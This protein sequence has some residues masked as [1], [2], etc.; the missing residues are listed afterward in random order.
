MVDHV[1]IKQAV[2]AAQQKRR[3]KDFPR[4]EEGY[5]FKGDG[6]SGF[7]YYR[8]GDQILEIYWEMSGVPQYDVLISLSEVQKWTSPDGLPIPS[9]KKDQ[10]V[11][12]LKDFLLA[13]KIRADF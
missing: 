1:A 9:Q 3:Q 12:G 6:R 4:L 7:V 11:S 8:E 10:I 2:Q 13:R 5:T